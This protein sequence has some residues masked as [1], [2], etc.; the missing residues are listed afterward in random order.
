MKDKLFR[1]RRAAFALIAGVGT[2][3]GVVAGASGISGA[4]PTTSVL[5]A[6]STISAA[7]APTIG[8]TAVNQAAGNL[9]LTLASGAYF[10]TGDTITLAVAA[11][12]GANEI[13]WSQNPTVTA[14]NTSGSTT[15]TFTL[16]GATTGSLV[17]TFTDTS[18]APST[19]AQT[20]TLSAVGYTTTGA[21][22]NITVTAA[23]ASATTATPGTFTPA[24]GVA[25]AT[26]VT[27]P[28]FGLSAASTPT[29]GAGLTSQ[30]GGNLNLSIY[31]AASTGWQQN[32]T[33]VIELDPTAGAATNCTGS[34]AAPIAVGLSATPTV[35][36]T[37]TTGDLSTAPTVTASLGQAGTCKGSAYD[38]ELILTF[39]N[40]GTLSATTT[41]TA[42]AAVITL[43]GISY[44]TGSSTPVGPVSVTASYAST[45]NAANVPGSTFE[46]NGTTPVTA[47]IHT[48]VAHGPSDATISQIVVGANNPAVSMSVGAINTPISNITVTEA[49]AA[50]VPTGYVC[51]TLTN[52]A[53]GAIPGAVFTA[54][55][56]PAVA[57]TSGNATVNTTVSGAG[58]ATLSFDVTASSTTASVFTLSKL[59]ANAPTGAYS[60]PV[61]LTVTDGRNATCTGG[62]PITAGALAAYTVGGSTVIAGSTADGT[63]AAE[64]E[65]VFNPST[66]GCVDGTVNNSINGS[67]YAPVILATD[68]NYPDALAAGYLAGQ[69]HT[70]VLLTPTNSLSPEAMQAMRLE[71]ITNVFI[72]GG[73]LAV[74]NAVQTQLQ[75]TPAYQCGG[76][77]VLTSFLGTAQNIQVTRIYGQTEYGTAADI[78]QYG[79]ASAV[80]SASFAG[81]FGLYNDTTGTSS[82]APATSA[83]VP[84]AILA[85]SQGAADAVAASALS[86][87]EQFPI[88]L[89]A[90]ASLS[91]DAQTAMQAL[92]IKQVIMMGG[93]IAISNSVVTSLQSMGISVLRIAGQDYTDTA[94]QLASFEVNTNTNSAGNVE[95]L[96]LDPGNTVIAARGDF[97]TDGLAGSV[98]AAGGLTYVIG[99]HFMPVLLT[100]NPTT[101]GKYLT[102]FLNTAGSPAGIDGIGGTVSGAV[103]SNITVLGGP[104]AVTPATIS[105]MQSALNG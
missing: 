56:T 100:L 49:A 48:A 59:A 47:D 61:F 77:A 89:T 76:N 17:L 99:G 50:A 52:A 72:V 53:L 10:N 15:P 24:S 63:A 41:G 97:Y 22:G 83:P 82:S 105:A 58:T 29:I 43:S 16:S 34:L 75:A 27:A 55:S 2:V 19:A 28:Y 86:Y 54:S 95:G 8:S 67:R 102:A 87:Y 26:L 78:A 98:V 13:V 38:N 23:Y 90:P 7:G 96:S 30:A 12:G 25:N 3:G 42:P 21:T 88:L 32:N 64:L 51:L 14:P 70:G 91:T 36:V 66:G 85:T 101:V 94:A 44:V 4:A 62:I 45:I 5:P 11:S 104:L 79:G 92:G 69:L 9:T 65:H 81:A 1:F 33:M 80:H 18:S 40:S 93:P 37:P 35:T 68:A 20:I 60:G 84:T 46:S 57:V 39:T 74:S 71:G 31:G 6:G 73:P 103:I